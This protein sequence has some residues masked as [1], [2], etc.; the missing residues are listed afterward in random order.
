MARG[1]TATNSQAAVFA[2]S[3]ATAIA[4]TM[5]EKSPA[6]ASQIA[7]H[8]ISVAASPALIQAN[9]AAVAL[10]AVNAAKIVSVPDVIQSDQKNALSV[11]QR[12]QSVVLNLRV[13]SQAPQAAAS[14]SDSLARVVRFTRTTAPPATAETAKNLEI[15]RKMAPADWEKLSSPGNQATQPALEMNQ[16]QPQLR[17]SGGTAVPAR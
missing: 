12:A 16:G 13:L 5:V 1:M 15:L 6:V 7:G 3:E 2:I 11:A 8:S 10:I 14:V 17:P 9:P 4:V